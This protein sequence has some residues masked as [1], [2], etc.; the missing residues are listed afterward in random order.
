M[1]TK[2]AENEIIVS[3]RNWI[4]DIVIGLNFCPF[5]RKP[6]TDEKITYQVDA[7]KDQEPALKAFQDC[8]LHLDT[9][10]EIETAL[11]IFSIGFSDFDDYLD[12]VEAAEEMIEQ[13]GYEGIYQVASFHPEY[14]FAGSNEDDPANYTNR[15]PYPMLHILREEQLEMAIE[16][17]TDVEGIPDRNIAKAKTLGLDYFRKRRF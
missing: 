15:S 8:C 17:H 16:K 14:V 6:F 12:L 9:H 11:L 7:T 3:T 13:E 2:P 5:A 4:R 10:P 1:N